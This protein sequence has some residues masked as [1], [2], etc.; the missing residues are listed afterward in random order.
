[1]NKKIQHIN[2]PE[3]ISFHDVLFIF[4]KHAKKIIVLTLLGLI[5]ATAVYLNH[6]T[7]YQSK[8][9]LLV[10]YVR[11]SRTVDPFEETKSTSGG[12]SADSVI[13]TEIEILNSTDLAEEVAKEVGVDQLLSG[14]VALSGPTLSSAAEEISKGMEVVP[15]QSSNVLYITYGNK[16]SKLSKLALNKIIELY[17]KKH[18][19]IHGGSI[20]PD[21]K[22]GRR[23]PGSPNT[24]GNA[25]QQAANRI[26]HSVAK[27]GHGSIVIPAGKDSRGADES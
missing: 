1:M 9:K 17:F 22:T 3:K 8:A 21:F 10:R 24:N 26:R 2:H 25:A 20:R 15:G 13:N 14:N 7:I 12:K 23:S 11:E 5:A 19:E 4:V 6:D 16:D 27:R 18:L